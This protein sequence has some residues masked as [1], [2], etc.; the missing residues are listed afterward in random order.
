MSLLKWPD[1]TGDIETSIV[2]SVFRGHWNWLKVSWG[3][4]L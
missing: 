4:E 1:K 2:K 3:Y